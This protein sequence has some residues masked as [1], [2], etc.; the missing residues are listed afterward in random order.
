MQSLHTDK[1][2]WRER[3]EEGTVI[4]AIIEDKIIKGANCWAEAK[5]KAINKEN[6]DELYI[7][8]LYEKQAYDH[9]VDRYS[10]EIAEAGTRTKEEKAWRDELKE[11]SKVDCI[12][13]STWHQSTVLDTRETTVDDRTFKEF[14]IG[15]RV[16][17]ESGFKS[18]SR[19][20]YEGLSDRFDGWVPYASPKLA[21]YYTKSQN[22]SFDFYD[23]QD[24]YD[25]IIKPKDGHDR[26]YA[27]PRLRKCMS[28]A[29]IDL[30]NEFGH[31]GGFEAILGLLENENVGFE[32]LSALMKIL[33]SNWMIFHKEFVHEYGVKVTKCAE[34]RIKNA[35]DAQLRNVKKERTE[36]VITAIDSLKRRFMN[37]NER[38]KES[39]RL[40]LDLSLMCLNSGQLNRR[41]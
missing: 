39:E 18:D 34:K 7:E 6:K 41:I 11:G 21:R 22:K 24:E 19:G 35:T 33:G 29:L 27:V 13:N 3:I 16:Y 36:A 30:V 2:E 10:I 20:F 37:K 26:V 32:L 4:D 9:F 12:D 1:S 38:E 31:L 23:I 25:S 14:N 15:Y 28:R 40:K 17:V 8:F 5:V